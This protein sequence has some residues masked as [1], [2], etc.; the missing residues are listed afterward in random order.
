MTSQQLIHTIRAYCKENT[1]EANILKYSRYFKQGLYD[2]WGL[3]QTQMDEKTK[4]LLKTHRITLEIVLEAAPEMIRNGKYEE[5]SFILLLVRGLHKQ[6][7][8]ETFESIKSWF[9]YG[10]NNW[11]HADTLGMMILPV[12]INMKI[13]QITDFQSWLTAS[14]KFRRRCVP[15]TLIKALKTHENYT[16][17][18]TFIECLMKDPEREV[19]QGTGWFLREAWKR[20][21]EETEAFLLRW[22]NTAARLIFQYA[23]EKMTKE[24]K[25]RFRREGNIL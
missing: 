10:I 9:E 21:P 19:H 22:K 24:G 17:L 5:I 25:L 7:T 16:S 15:V 2:A 23:T 6:F 1:N 11:A 3:S 8:R 14:N 18:F 20:K 12:F 4:E 13:L